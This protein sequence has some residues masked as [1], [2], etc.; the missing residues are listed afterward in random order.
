M[1][2]YAVYKL[3]HFL[4]MFILVTV[5]A[6]A[7]MHVLRGGTRQDNPYRRVLAIMHGLAAFLILLGGFGMLARL[8]IVQ[9]GLPTWVI[10]KLGIWLLLSG[11]IA[12]VYRGPGMARL[13]LISM[14]LLVVIAAAIAMYKPF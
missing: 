3:I 9:A 8:G 2:P 5:L 11:A 7:S 12:L 1:V 13:L 4:G 6:A 10:L 14:P